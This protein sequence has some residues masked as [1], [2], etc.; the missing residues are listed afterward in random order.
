MISARE[1]E[2][3]CVGRLGLLQD[4]QRGGEE[5]GFTG[6]ENEVTQSSMNAHPTMKVAGFGKFHMPSPLPAPV[7]ISDDRSQVMRVLIAGNTRIHN[8]NRCTQ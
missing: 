2:K 3:D 8:L 5:R 4:L 7:Q 6:N 1:K